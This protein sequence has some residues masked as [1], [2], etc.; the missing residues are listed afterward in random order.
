[1]CC[2][3][4][5][6][7]RQETSPTITH[8]FLIHTLEI[9]LEGCLLDA[10]IKFVY[11]FLLELNP[12]LAFHVS[13]HSFSIICDRFVAWSHLQWLEHLLGSKIGFPREITC[14]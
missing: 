1:M 13:Y 7:F 11:L 4:D 12:R 3:K 14:L 8:I 6:I 5:I 10:M 9:I 2:S